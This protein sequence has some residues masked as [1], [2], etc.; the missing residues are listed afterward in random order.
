VELYYHNPSWGMN[1]NPNLHPESSRQYELGVNTQVGKDTLDAALFTNT[2]ENQ[3]RWDFVANTFMNV[4]NARQRGIEITWDHPFTSATRVSMFYTYLDARSLT[5]GSRLSGI[6]YN[7]IGMTLT[8]RMR[9]FNMALTGRWTTNRTYG[10]AVS[11]G[12]A[13]FDLTL[14]RQ[15]DKTV[16]P[17]LTIRNLT[18]TSY[19]EIAGYPGEGRSFELG[20]RTNW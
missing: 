14:V 5:D 11:A 4:D 7:Q 17:Y 8:S 12:R 2:V 18:N 20:V 9:Q 16:S 19:E 13:V 15:T 3:I 6:P 10:T 1:G